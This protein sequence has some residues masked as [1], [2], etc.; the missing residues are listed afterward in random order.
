MVSCIV[1]DDFYRFVGIDFTLR[2]CPQGYPVMVN[3][4]IYYNFVLKFK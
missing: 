4:D 3:L 2:A 1:Q